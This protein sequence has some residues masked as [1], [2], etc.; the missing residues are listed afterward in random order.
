MSDDQSSEAAL[1]ELID[2]ITAAFDGV[3]REDGVT[4]HEARVIDDYGDDDE[5]SDARRKDTDT[6]WQDVPKKWIEKFADTLPF[7]CPKGFRYYIPAFM[8]YALKH[9]GTSDCVSRA[10]AFQVI[11]SRAASSMG[12]PAVP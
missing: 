1:Q 10:G 9:Y 7:M 8:M 2:L 4:L 6:R 5:R 11:S 12:P 3:S